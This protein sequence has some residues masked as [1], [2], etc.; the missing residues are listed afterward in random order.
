MICMKHMKSP[1]LLATLFFLSASPKPAQ[2]QG[3][4]QNLNFD[5]SN[6]PQN[7]PPGNVS[8]LDALPGWSVYIG[9]NQAFQVFYNDF[10][11]GSTYVDLLGTNGV[12]GIRSIEGGYSV[13]LQGGTSATDA[14]IRQ[15]GTVP[16]GTQSILFAAQAG[17]GSIIVS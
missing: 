5:S 17:L 9:T 14:S 8:S 6:I 16:S 3:S 12:F 1:T 4:F 7:H 15:T 2:S 10:A 11:I 13:F